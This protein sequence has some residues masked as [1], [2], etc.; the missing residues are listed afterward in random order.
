MC[1]R[2]FSRMNTRTGPR[3]AG[4]AERRPQP[5]KSLDLLLPPAFCR[6][7][8][9]RTFCDR[10]ITFQLIEKPVRGSSVP[11]S[12]GARSNSHPVLCEGIHRVG[13]MLRV[14]V[15]A[16]M[17]RAQ[18]VD[19]DEQDVG[20]FR[21]LVLGDSLAASLGGLARRDRRRKCDPRESSRDCRKLSFCV[22]SS[23]HPVSK[24][25]TCYYLANRARPSAETAEVL[26]RLVASHGV[27]PNTVETARSTLARPMTRDASAAACAPSETETEPIC[28]RS[29]EYRTRHL[30]RC[31]NE[32]RAPRLSCS[33]SGERLSEPRLNKVASRRPGSPLPT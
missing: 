21:P 1:R 13:R 22:H 17:I 25:P 20:R 28:H 6:R 7:R 29:T 31:P 27:S 33:N 8:C 18:S 12:N 9:L 5:A 15:R 4:C 32:A 19:Q 26:H 24:G 2:P 3:P 10:A 11:S 30:Q 23:S 16:E 14:S